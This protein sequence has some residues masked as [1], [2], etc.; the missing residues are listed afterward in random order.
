MPA[1]AVVPR[2]HR[3]RDPAHDLDAEH[4][5]RQDIAAARP[6]SLGDREQ[7]RQERRRDVAGQRQHGVVVVERVGGG[8]VPE[9]RRDRGCRAIRSEDRRRTLG[10]G[11][12]LAEE[13]SH[14]LVDAA[15]RHAP[16]VEHGETAHLDGR[17][18][19][20]LEGRLSHPGEQ[21]RSR[22]RG[23]SHDALRSERTACVPR[24]ARADRFPIAA[25]VMEPV[26][27]RRPDGRPRPRRPFQVTR[28]LSF[29]PRAGP[30]HGRPCQSAAGSPRRPSVGSPA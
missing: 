21:D 13:A 14:R 2:R 10:L 28:S 22:S 1:G 15:H 24:F 3:A 12:G 23:T 4:E 30:R 5:G 16:P 26:L 9:G 6:S 25:L 18:R 20:R 19:Q 29:D 11:H 27:S 17:L 8:A 7:S